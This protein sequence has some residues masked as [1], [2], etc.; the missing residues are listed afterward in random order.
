[1][2]CDQVLLL[3]YHLTIAILV[4]FTIVPTSYYSIY[5]YIDTYFLPI[6]IL[7]LYS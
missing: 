4:E 2:T 3:Q 1:M 7:L 6:T 5:I